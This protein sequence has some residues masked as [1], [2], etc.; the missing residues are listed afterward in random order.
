MQDIKYEHVKELSLYPKEYTIQMAIENNDIINFGVVPYNT[1]YLDQFINN[2]LN[3]IPDKVII[4]KYPIDGYPSIGILQSTGDLIIY[5][6]RYYENSE[7]PSYVTYYGTSITVNNERI[8][9]MLQ[10]V[11]YLQTINNSNYEV[12]RAVL[13]RI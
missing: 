13:G 4:V 12:F 9:D 6:K 5:T 7:E 8:R 10:R 3:Q 1:Q 11:Y 2:Y